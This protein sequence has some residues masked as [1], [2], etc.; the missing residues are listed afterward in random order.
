MIE[1]IFC[2]EEKVYPF[3]NEKTGKWRMYCDACGANGGVEH[4]SEEAG[5]E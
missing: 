2:N 5:G 4:E 1:C 3:Q